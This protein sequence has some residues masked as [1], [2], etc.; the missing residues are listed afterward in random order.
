MVEPTPTGWGPSSYGYNN[1]GSLPW[2]DTGW[3]LDGFIQYDRNEAWIPT[4]ESQVVCPSDMIALGDS[5]LLPDVDRAGSPPGGTLVLNMPVLRFEV[6]W[7]PVMRGLPAG[8]SSVRA[9]KQRHGGRWNIAFCDG[10][11]ENLRPANLF[12][13]TKA[14]VAQRWN[15]DHQPHNDPLGWSPPPPPR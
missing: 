3:G 12:D 4:R 10:H 15:N 6:C 1:G 13:I 11:V 2:V 14:S 9:T 8:D 5:T 7:N